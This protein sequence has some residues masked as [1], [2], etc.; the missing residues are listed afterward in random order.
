MS[1]PLRRIG[2][3]ELAR[4]LPGIADEPDRRF[5][6]FMGAGCPPCV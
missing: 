5:A 4:R 3:A 6:F 1:R 2:A